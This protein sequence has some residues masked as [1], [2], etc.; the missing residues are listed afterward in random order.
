MNTILNNGQVTRKTLA[1]LLCITLCTEVFADAG[2]ANRALAWQHRLLFDPDSHQLLRENEGL[3]FIYDGITD[4]TIDRVMEE[5]FD[6]LSSMMFIRT[7]ITDDH[8]DPVLEDKGGA[9]P[10]EDDGC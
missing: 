4:K 9:A 8:G 1:G 7:V 6:R 2:G 3:V 5:Q 10:L